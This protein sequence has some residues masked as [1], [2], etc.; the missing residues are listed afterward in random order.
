MN[1]EIINL[2]IDPATKKEAQKVAEELGFSLSSILKGYL[3]HFIRTKKVRFSLVEEE[4]SEYLIQMLQDSNEDI[5]A[6]RVISFKNWEEE[7]K[8]L[9]E[10]IL[11][12]EL[13]QNPKN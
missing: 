5:K 1:T 11:K 6:G 13:K 10:K 8:Y 7:K 3:K 9:E 2:K 4:P 12:D